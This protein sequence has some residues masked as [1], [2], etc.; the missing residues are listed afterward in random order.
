[1]ALK[2]VKKDNKNILVYNDT[3]SRSEE[4][5]NNIKWLEYCKSNFN[6]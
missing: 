4:Y 2:T 3:I 6:E 1:M 5:K